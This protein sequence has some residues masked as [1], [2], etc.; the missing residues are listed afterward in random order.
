MASINAPLAASGFVGA[1]TSGVVTGLDPL[2]PDGNLKSL[3]AVLAGMFAA[4]ISFE[5]MS[6][7]VVW[8]LR[9]TKRSLDSILP[10]FQ[11]IEEQL[12]AVIERQVEA[13]RQQNA[14]AAL[15]R[16]IEKVRNEAAASVVR[17]M[18]EITRKSIE[19]VRSL[20]T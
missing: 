4:L 7:F 19:V 6:W 13:M 20:N 16:E 18:N 10:H 2:L 3:V 9:A 17:A 11:R 14:P 1:L 15:L 5:V 12:Q 8:R